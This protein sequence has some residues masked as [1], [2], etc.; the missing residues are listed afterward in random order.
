VLLLTIRILLAAVLVAAGMAKLLDRAGTEFALEEFSVPE[1]FVPWAAT[2][3]PAAELGAAGGLL[4]DPLVRA[5]AGA[6]LVLLL[7]FAG[8]ILR[9]LRAG[10]TPDCHCFGQLHSEP[11]GARTLLRN[12]VLALAAA[13]VT[14]L[15]PGRTFDDVSPIGFV[16]LI[17]ALLVLGLSLYTARL[18]DELARATAPPPEPGPLSVGRRLPPL[19]LRDLSRAG[20]PPVKL[21]ELAGPAS[22]LLVVLTSSGCP[23]CAALLPAVARWQTAL[24][25]QLSVVVVGLG[26]VTENRR[27]AAVHAVQRLLAD[28]DDAVRARF[29]PLP[30]PG[31]VLLDPD[32]R[33]AAGPV[34]G[35]V[36][37]EA[38]IRSHR[39]A[40]RPGVLPP[41][42]DPRRRLR[43]VVAARAAALADSRLGAA[44][45]E[46]GRP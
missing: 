18:R 33:I 44:T 9:A 30:T 17:L 12:A 32:G 43:E 7:V 46:P 20:E 26:P 37:I 6:A 31:A 16:E 10:R 2:L 28:P 4:I 39:S 5:G 38:M 8:G 21:S 42:V 14:G 25:D 35:P 13:T 36:G 11:A 19:V 34:I 15:G 29:G 27:L 23:A 41:P 24:S 40:P 3:L 22:P 1:R 45:I